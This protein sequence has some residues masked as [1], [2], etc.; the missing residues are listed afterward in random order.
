MRAQ[1][2]FIWCG[3][4]GIG[5][6]I[7]GQGRAYVFQVQVS[8]YDADE[9]STKGTQPVIVFRHPLL[10]TLALPML[11]FVGGAIV[12]ALVSPLP[13]QAWRWV[14]VLA[15]GCS[16]ALL[17]SSW[18]DTPERIAGAAAALVAFATIV[19]FV[20]VTQYRFLEWEDEFGPATRIG[21]LISNRFPLYY[22]PWLPVNA[23]A[24][25]FEA[26]LPLALGLAFAYAGWKRWA[27]GGAILWLALGLFVTASRGAWL[28]LA[29]TLLVGGLAVLRTRS[30]QLA[31]VMVI[32]GASVLLCALLIFVV[33][34][35]VRPVAIESVI[36]RAIDRATLY[37][38]S[39]YL[40]LD[41]PFTGIGGGSVFTLA[42]SRMQLMVNE[43]FLT[44]PH[45]LLLS[46]WLW[47]GLLGLVGFGILTLIA[48]RLVWRT[49]PA[50][51]S[52]GLGAALSGLT[53]L[54]HGITDA[55]QYDRI[56][57]LLVNCAIFGILCAAA[58][59]ADPR[60]LHWIRL[61]RQSKFGGG[62]VI[63]LVLLLTGP[64]ILARTA[65]NIASL[66]H[67]QVLL[68]DSDP[69][70]R[71]ALLQDARR[72]TEYGLTIAPD[73]PAVL[74][75]RGLLEY[76]LGNYE[77]AADVLQRA[78]PELPEDQA[79]IKALGYT[80]IWSGQI[81]AGAQLL[82]TLDRAAEIPQ[83]L[84]RWEQYWIEHG[85]GDLAAHAR[86]AL[87]RFP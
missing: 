8:R 84:M 41:V 33:T 14:A 69:T 79:T 35:A 57:T 21:M 25:L 5:W 83:E 48:G 31:R 64:R 11:L 4:A 72:W 46:V 67:A 15:F 74:K 38:N 34:A 54:L 26:A 53:S 27:A 68:R 37:R 24:A 40:A 42:Y 65:A 80:R 10:R 17:L 3:S 16:G 73:T 87:Q 29:I 13:E 12:A 52:V 50:L 9:H 62:V 76:T 61:N 47:H 59:L 7:Q 71:Q 30:A 6:T 28:A 82:G 66:L 63:A 1:C 81:E 86:A 75:A 2:T 19:A 36:A 32:G 22:D 44:Y 85:R 45:N 60:P 23:S 51:G 55:P 39:L 20:T 56:T 77:Q 49:L 43:P 78:I 18:L 70:S 58:S